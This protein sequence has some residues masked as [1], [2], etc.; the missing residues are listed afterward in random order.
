MHHARR[1]GSIDDLC[2]FSLDLFG[3]ALEWNHTCDTRLLV[4]IFGSAST[5]STNVY[6][7]DADGG[8]DT[9]LLPTT[10]ANEAATLS[11]RSSA[12]MSS[13]LS[14]RECF[15]PDVLSARF[16]LFHLSWVRWRGLQRCL[17]SRAAVIHTYCHDVIA[18]KCVR[19]MKVFFSHFIR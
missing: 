7:G 2:S 13:M 17:S 15:Q 9:W 4:P 8:S 6:G 5:A 1:I 3:Q 11:S 12:G 16:L 19:V 14:A 10:A 18:L